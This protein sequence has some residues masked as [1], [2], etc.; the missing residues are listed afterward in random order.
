MPG[1]GPLADDGDDLGFSRRLVGLRSRGVVLLLLLLSAGVA[2][3]SRPA[4]LLVGLVG[5]EVTSRVEG[6]VSVASVAVRVR[7]LSFIRRHGKL[8]AG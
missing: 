8:R 7:V 1:F 6:V 5:A 2:E 4:A 3:G